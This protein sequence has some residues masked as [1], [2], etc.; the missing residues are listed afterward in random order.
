MKVQELIGMLLS[1]PRLQR[2][3]FGFEQIQVPSNNVAQ[4][5]TCLYGQGG[6]AVVTRS[7]VGLTQ[8]Y[9]PLASRSRYADGSIEDGPPT[10]FEGTFPFTLFLPQHAP[11]LGRTGDDWII[12]RVDAA[13][14]TQV[15]A[16]LHHLDADDYAATIDVALPWGIITTFDAPHQYARLIDLE[17]DQLSEADDQELHRAAA[18]EPIDRATPVPGW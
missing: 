18:L 16:T 9:S 1:P 7:D 8:Y 14:D 6:V 12:D 2:A 3:R 4:A 11:I 5:G 13:S 10:G 15:R 17:I